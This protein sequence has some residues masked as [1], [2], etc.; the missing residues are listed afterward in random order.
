MSITAAQRR[1]V[2]QRAGDCCEYCRLTE[3]DEL[4]PFHVDHIVPRKNN[5]TDDLDNLCLACYMCNLFKGSNM[6]AADPLTGAAAFLF[7]PRT[8]IWDDHF[9]INPDAALT[10]KTPEGRVTIN[11]MRMNAESQVQY[12]QFTMRTGEY[13]CKKA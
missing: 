8:Q 4:A 5:G 2:I 9:T 7:N 12:R 10:G 1:A 6:A 11:V 3:I 13:P